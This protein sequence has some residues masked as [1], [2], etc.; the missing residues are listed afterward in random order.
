MPVLKAAIAN[1]PNNVM[2]RL[3]MLRAKL[4]KKGLCYVTKPLEP[5]WILE[6][7]NVT[8]FWANGC[9]VTKV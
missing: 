6:S 8:C 2:L 1:E 3:V 7:Y 9:R 4:R 5:A